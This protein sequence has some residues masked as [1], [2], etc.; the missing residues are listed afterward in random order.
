MAMSV[1]GD[2]E[3]RAEINVTPLVDV[4]LVLLVILLLVAMMGL[5][6]CDK[7][8]K[9]ARGPEGELVATR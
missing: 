4:V 1:S 2:D 3:I 8:I 9:E 7:R 6:A 5:S